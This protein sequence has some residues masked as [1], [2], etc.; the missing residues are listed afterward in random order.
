MTLRKLFTDH[1]FYTKFVI[2]SIVDGAPDLEA[3]LERLMQNQKD[4]GDQVKPIVG[5]ANGNRLTE[6]LSEHIRLAGEVIKAAKASTLEGRSTTLKGKVRELFRNS[7]QV[8][9]LLSS[10]NPK[11]LPYEDM[12]QMFREHNQFVIDMT[13]ARL[14]KQYRL[15]IR[16]LDA[17]YNQ[18]LRM[19][20]Q[21]FFAL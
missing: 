3:L 13:M 18:L 14:T 11:A 8:A 20:D 21:I 16:I 15:E 1:G 2:N 7:D 10:F 6:V 4:I 5:E 12:V 17:Y 19:S 9:E